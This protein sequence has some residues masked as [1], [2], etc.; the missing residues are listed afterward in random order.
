MKVT[1]GSVHIYKC[2]NILQ[3]LAVRPCK[4]TYRNALSLYQRML[5]GKLKPSKT[6]MHACIIK[7]KDPHSSKGWDCI[8]QNI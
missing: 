5:K 8:Q 6:Y 2:I 1:S 7:S 3:R 4:H